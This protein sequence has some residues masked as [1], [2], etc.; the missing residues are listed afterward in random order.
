ML[1]HTSIVIENTVLLR[2]GYLNLTGVYA[3]IFRV[4]GTTCTDIDA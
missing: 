3:V 2:V 1:S 4:S